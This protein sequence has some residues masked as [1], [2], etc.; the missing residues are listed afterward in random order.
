MAIE[1]CEFDALDDWIKSL[2][3]S[4]AWQWQRR[5]LGPPPSAPGSS[6]GK[7]AVMAVTGIILVLFLVAHM[8]AT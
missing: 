3:A 2:L 1:D 7:K 8:S 6:V 4:I 5:Q